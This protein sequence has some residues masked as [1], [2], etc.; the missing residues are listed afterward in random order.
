MMVAS[1]MDSPSWGM[2]MGMFKVSGS[3]FKVQSS[4]PEVQSPKS[5]VA[6]RL[7]CAVFRRFCSR[8]EGCPK[9]PEYLHLTRIFGQPGRAKENSPPIHRWVR[10]GMGDKSRQ[11]RQSSFVPDGTCLASPFAP[12]DESV[13]YFL[14]PCRAGQGW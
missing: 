1:A 13:G 6:K 10:A 7:E 2:M 14:S 5:K 8:R 4:K 3:K 11:G 12:T 9:A